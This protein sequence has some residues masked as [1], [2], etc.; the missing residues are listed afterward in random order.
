MRVPHVCFIIAEDWYFW[1][2][3]RLLAQDLIRR[4]CRVD[5]MTNLSG[6]RE[7]IEAVGVIPHSLGLQRS[8]TNPWRDAQVI[9]R[10]TSTL[11]MLE[12]DVVHLVG[13]KPIIYGSIA[14]RLASVPATVC[15][16]AGLGWLFTPGGSLKTTART[17]VKLYFRQALAKRADIHFIVQNSHHRDV[18]AAD[19]MASPEQ[20]TLVHGAGV[21]VNRFCYSPEPSGS[22]VVLTHARMLWDKGIGEV[23]EAARDLKK[24][25]VVCTFRLVGDPD[26]AN[27]ASIPQSQLDAWNNEG[28]V[29]WEGRRT[30]I[31]RVLSQSHIACLPSYHEGFPLSLVEAAACGRPV[32]TT[33]V[34]G[35]RD[36]V[37]HGETGLVVPVKQSGSLANALHEMIGNVERRK[38]FGRAGRNRVLGLMSGKIVNDET[39]RCYERLLEGIPAESIP[40][41]TEVPARRAA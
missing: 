1:S 10:M 31:P 37:E 33:D 27:P 18:L 9:R 29:E 36:V 23:V 17:L 38:T 22:P 24:R 28:I 7:R 14:A 6:L 30:D 5:L 21:D 16:V 20:I 3:R 34:P 32:V 25:G 2:H 26:P 35:C 11:R 41:E 40:R 8:G 13:M 4:G 39:Y 15:A 12:P 19:G